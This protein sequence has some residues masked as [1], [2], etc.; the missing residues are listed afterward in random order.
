M[1]EDQGHTGMLSEQAFISVMKF[2]VEVFTNSFLD[3]FKL[4]Y[5]VFG[6]GR[7]NILSVL[8]DLYQ[9]HKHYPDNIGQFPDFPNAPP[10][11]PR[12]VMNKFCFQ[13]REQN[14]KAEELASELVDMSRSRRI[15]TSIL[16]LKIIE[17][18]EGELFLRKTGS[19][20]PGQVADANKHPMMRIIEIV[21]CI[22]TRCIGNIVDF[23]FVQFLNS[24]MNYD[25]RLFLDNLID[26]LDS[27]GDD[28]RSYISKCIGQDESVNLPRLQAFLVG[29]GYD[30]QGVRSTFE[31]LKLT[32]LD[33]MPLYK[34]QIKLEKEINLL[35]IV[36]R[37]EK[38]KNL[39]Y[40]QAAAGH[41]S[42][43]EKGVD[44]VITQIYDGLP[45]PKDFNAYF[46]IPTRKTIRKQELGKIMAMNLRVTETAEQAQLLNICQTAQD[47]EL[48]SLEKLKDVYDSKYSLNKRDLESAAR[49]TE[50]TIK[51]IRQ[52]IGKLGF[53]VAALFARADANQTNN[54]DRSEFYFLL[55]QLDDTITRTETNKIFLMLDRD[56]SGTISLSE[57]EAFFKVEAST[58]SGSLQIE[59]LRWA[60]DIFAE[61]NKK[62]MLSG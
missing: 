21:D 19:Q 22:D 57:F 32:G 51:N 41:I 12:Q 14:I 46:G 18:M 47:P 11:D 48:I 37:P 16:M 59:K 13:L 7:I 5:E 45:Y 43:L 40:G 25:V 36:D 1:E 20:G 33:E 17:I 49:E 58:M 53:N 4:K 6:D 50:S 55:Y 26:R 23:E 61:L 38:T 56:N 10:A 15:K 27:K 8:Y 24:F 62:L 39:L 34:L 52:V 60:R 31:R 28:F 30:S 54:L 9:V 2:T 29:D 44:K 3:L 35:K 42:A